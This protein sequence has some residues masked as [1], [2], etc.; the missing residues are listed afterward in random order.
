MSPLEGGRLSPLPP[1]PFLLKL[2]IACSYVI[3][4]M[5]SNKNFKTNCNPFVSQCGSVVE[6]VDLRVQALKFNMMKMIFFYKVRSLHQNMANMTTPII[7]VY[8]HKCH[9][10]LHDYVVSMDTLFIH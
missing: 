9:S 4:V 1:L 5:F 6:Q 2:L 10:L 7:W 3:E 8:S